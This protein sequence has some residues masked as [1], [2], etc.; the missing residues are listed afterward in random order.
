MEIT[1]L[2]TH[3]ISPEDYDRLSPVF[4]VVGSHGD[5]CLVLRS[6]DGAYI[7][8]TKAEQANNRRNTKTL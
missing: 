1:D 7:C 5:S 6:V 8:L 2:V 4:T 3:V